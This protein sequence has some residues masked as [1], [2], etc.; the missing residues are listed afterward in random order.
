MNTM[1]ETIFIAFPEK[2]QILH[3]RPHVTVYVLEQAQGQG[4]P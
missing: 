1:R 3:T 4:V 2:P